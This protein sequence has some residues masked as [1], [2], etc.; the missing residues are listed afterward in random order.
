MSLFGKDAGSREAF[1]SV[2]NNRVHHRQ[3]RIGDES[4]LKIDQDF[5]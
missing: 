1:P 2:T 4:I 3:H 5:T